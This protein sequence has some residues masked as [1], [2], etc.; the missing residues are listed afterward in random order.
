MMK[1]VL[2]CPNMSRDRDLSLTAK[3]RDIL[4]P[5]LAEIIVCPLF[6]EECS[7]PRLPGVAVSTLEQELEGASMVVVFGGDGTILRAARAAAEKPF[8]FSASIWREGLHG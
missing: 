5:C 4:Q 2:L 7:V 3:V 1:R 8:P 6:D